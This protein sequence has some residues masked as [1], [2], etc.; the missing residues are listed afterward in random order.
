MAFLAAGECLSV[1][2]GHFVPGSVV[3][4][5]LLFIALTTKVI[6]PHRIEKVAHFLTGNMTIFFIPAVMGIIDLWGVIKMSWLGWLGVIVLS[7][8]CV[9]ATTGYTVEG[10][11]FLQR[12]KKRKGEG[13]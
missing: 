10:V 9:M 8:I 11:R 2:M 13:K 6:K 4:M 12:Q 3:G 7:T 5:M 1:L